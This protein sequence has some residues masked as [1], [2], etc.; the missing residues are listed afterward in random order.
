MTPVRVREGRSALVMAFPHSGTY[1]PDDVRRDLN[2]TGQFLSDTDW[3]LP[4]L[5][6]GLLPSATTVTAE[7]HR[8]VID[9]N[10]DP[11]GQS[12]Y[13]G[14]ATTGLIPETDFDGNP[15]WSRVPDI[16]QKM[17]RQVA[18]HEAYHRALRTALHRARDR[19][20]FA[21]LYD[22]HSIRSQIPRL[23]DGTLPDFNIGTFDGRSCDACLARNVE[24][25]CRDARRF[26]CVV[27]G[28]FKG[29][30]TTRHYGQPTK[31]IHAIQMELAQ[32]THLETE[33]SP[34]AY[35]PEKSKV[36]RPFL[37]E[38][39]WNIDQWRP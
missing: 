3:Y 33:T 12:L 32:S 24:A 30:W 5:Y 38:V 17:Q 23:F 16:A 29:G 34:W 7:F 10:R 39:L 19:H 4:K 27:N 36:L 26:T 37:E 15:I 31:G 25:V 2:E 9:A 8:Y 28:R 20:G 22:C 18:Y 14:Q 11:S 6:D 13:P 21:I 35:S 1:L